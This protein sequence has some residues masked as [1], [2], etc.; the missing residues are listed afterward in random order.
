[1]TVYDTLVLQ[2]RAIWQETKT[3]EWLDALIYDNESGEFFFIELRKE[4]GE[5]MEDFIAK[6]MEIATE[7]FDSPSFT[8]LVDA[9]YAEAMGYDTY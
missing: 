5:D 1:M 3:G 7:N 8:K 9:E 4:E 2:D 6:C